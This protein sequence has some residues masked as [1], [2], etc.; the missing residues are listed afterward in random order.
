MN[1]N[2]GCLWE[3]KPHGDI[4][5]GSAQNRCLSVINSPR[6][7]YRKNSPQAT[8]VCRLEWQCSEEPILASGQKTVT[9]ETG[10]PKAP[11][12]ERGFTVVLCKR[13]C[14]K[15][16][17]TL[18]HNIRPPNLRCW[19]FCFSILAAFCLVFPPNKTCQGYQG[20]QD[21]VISMQ[22]S[23]LLACKNKEINQKIAQ[24]RLHSVF[25]ESILLLH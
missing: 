10:L 2:G 13:S 22:E 5:S 24:K 25:N 19:H 17:V 16:C 6:G 15:G 3:Y 7:P 20:Y 14:I 23:I 1:Y 18:L 9:M 21:G 8:N 11:D 12:Q 4:Q